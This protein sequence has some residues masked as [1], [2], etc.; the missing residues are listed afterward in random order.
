MLQL[1]RWLG[2]LRGEPG[3][4]RMAETSRYLLRDI[5]HL[6]GDGGQAV[7]HA[8]LAAGARQRRRHVPQRHKAC[9][10]TDTEDTEL[11]VVIAVCWGRYP[12]AQLS[13]VRKS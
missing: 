9:G 11:C 7:A 3:F 10:K 2:L 6:G 5:T 13:S 12:A 4:V 8:L 1:I